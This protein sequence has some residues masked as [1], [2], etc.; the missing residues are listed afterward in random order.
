MF[1][2]TV[3]FSK[4]VSRLL[5][6]SL[7]VVSEQQQHK[8]RFCIS[9]APVEMHHEYLCLTF[10]T[11]GMSGAYYDALGVVCV[12]IKTQLIKTVE[13]CQITFDTFRM[14]SCPTTASFA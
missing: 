5:L 8:Y 2:I 6:L 11:V 3:V 9:S 10:C 13:I 1:Y 14:R 12:T 4:V 7:S